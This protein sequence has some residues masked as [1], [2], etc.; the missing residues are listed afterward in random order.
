[1]EQAPDGTDAALA[2]DSNFVLERFGLGFDL[3]R[4]MPR[5]SRRLNPP[6]HLD[7]LSDD[8]VLRLFSRAPFVTHGTL[9]VVCR[10]LKTLLRSPEFLQ[11]RVDSGLV[12]HGLV[13]AGGLGDG[14]ITADCSM[15]TCG[16][17]RPI[18]QLRCPRHSACSAIVEDEDGQPEM[19]VMGGRDGEDNLATVEAYNPRTN[20]WR[21]CLPL[22]QRRSCAVGGV[23]GGCLVVAGG[24]C[25]RRLTS[26]EAYSPTGW[27]PLPPLPHEAFLSTACVLNGRLYVMGGMACNKLQVLEKSEENGFS[28]TVKAQLPANRHDA[29]SVVRDGKIWVIGGFGDGG[30][31]DSVT[32]YDPEHDSWGT[33]PALPSAVSGGRA[34]THDGDIHLISDIPHR[35]CRGAAWRAAE[36]GSLAKRSACESVLLG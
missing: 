36:P 33:G 29:A 8:L 28:W 4:V 22:R 35:V 6:C 2:P 14:D 24:H 5:R 20:T 12:E 25:N 34:V 21:S 15:F 17:W 19:W 32:I 9:H 31:T 27:T 1:M 30:L 23:V 13:V 11:Q 16:R 7:G 10:R 3:D 26:V 18:T